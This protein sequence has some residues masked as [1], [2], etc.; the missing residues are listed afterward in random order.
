MRPSRMICAA[1]WGCIENIN[2]GIKQA[3]G[4]DESRLSESVN[5]IIFLLSF[6]RA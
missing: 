1:S 2:S 4:D 6:V 3:L 5:Y